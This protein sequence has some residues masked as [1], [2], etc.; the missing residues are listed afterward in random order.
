M[1]KT[2]KRNFLFAKNEA[3]IFC[4]TD[5]DVL[6]KTIK[7]LFLLILIG[8]FSLSAP[9][10]KSSKK[11]KAAQEKAALEAKLAKE[12]EEHL[13]KEK[14][15]RRQEAEDRANNGPGKKV[16]DYFQ[17][18]ST[19]SAPEAANAKIE[20][21]LGLFSSPDAPVLIVIKKTGSEVD[22]DKPTTIQKYLNYLKDQKKTFNKVDK[23]E[24]DADGK[25]KELI[26]INK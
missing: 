15:K 11:A 19:A 14:E 2:V 12:K 1:E 18:V 17:A 13:R 4:L 9:A 20:E 23:I 24:Y 7:S 16:E 22:Y 10:C 26:L 6:K 21:A 3:G 25:I 5:D 8:L